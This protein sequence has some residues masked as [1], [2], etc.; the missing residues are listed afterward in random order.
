MKNL[1][2]IIFIITLSCGYCL[3]GNQK[4][5]TNKDFVS[6]TY[7]VFKIDS[8]NSYYLIYCRKDNLNYKIIS[9]K[10][11]KKEGKQIIVVENFY[12]FKLINFPNYSDNENPL[13]GFSSTE[14]CIMLDKDTSICKEKG[15]TGL[16]TTNNLQGLYY[17]K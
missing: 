10:E 4:K 1:I 13:T 16:Y 7:K 12:S 14:P 17:I 2:F 9:K 8:I 5:D 15:V 6:D 11:S 3:K